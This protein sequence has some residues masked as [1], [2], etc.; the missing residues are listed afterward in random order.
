MDIQQNCF[1]KINTDLHT[2]ESR[3]FILTDITYQYFTETLTKRKHI[4][5]MPFKNLV[6]AMYIFDYILRGTREYRL[7]KS[8]FVLGNSVRDKFCEVFGYSTPSEFYDMVIDLCKFGFIKRIKRGYMYPDDSI[9][10]NMRGKYDTS[11]YMLCKDFYELVK[12]VM[13]IPLTA[14]EYDGEQVMKSEIGAHTVRT[15]RYDGK[16][17]P[18]RLEII[19]AYPHVKKYKIDA[20]KDVIYTYETALDESRIRSGITYPVILESLKNVNVKAELKKGEITDTC[21]INIPEVLACIAELS[22]KAGQSYEANGLCSDYYRYVNQLKICR[23]ILF[24]ANMEDNTVEMN[25][26]R[27]VHGRDYLPHRS[28]QMLSSEYRKR[29]LSDYS[30]LDVKSGTQTLLWNKAASI[31]GK[32]K[33]ADFF[34]LLSEYVKDPDEIRNKLTMFVM[35]GAKEEDKPRYKDFVKMALNVPFFGS[36]NN[37]KLTLADEFNYTQKSLLKRLANQHNLPRGVAINLAENDYYVSYCKET[38]KF[39]SFML[40]QYKVNTEI[41]NGKKVCTYTNDLGTMIQSSPR[42]VGTPIAHIYQGIEATVRDTIRNY[43]I[44]GKKL[45]DHAKAI[46]LLL[47]DGLYIKHDIMKEILKQEPIEHYLKRTLGY[48]IHFSYDD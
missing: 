44:H 7:D 43:K 26:H 1:D 24:H 11:Y 15:F 47:H 41:V 25:Y 21:T 8:Y 28:I 36:I 22:D 10:V 42:K 3:K 38:R 30:T 46:G 19:K 18:G 14:C 20:D 33:T 13:G 39:I 5:K 4:R 37:P 32:E 31:L 40:K 6:K 45:C 16:I 27:N 23:N 34:P 35:D 17:F 48:D 9:H 12:T 29:I 2:S